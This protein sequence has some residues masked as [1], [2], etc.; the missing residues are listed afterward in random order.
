MMS[1]SEVEALCRLL[2]RQERLAVAHHDARAFPAA[3]GFLR[4]IH[5]HPVLASAI[6]DLVAD[7]LRIREGHVKQCRILIKKLQHWCDS[8]EAL[9]GQKRVDLSPDKDGPFSE[10]VRE[11]LQ[12]DDPDTA[13]CACGQLQDIFEELT[14]WVGDLC[15]NAGAE[16]L[17]QLKRSGRA[18]R[19][20][21]HF[22]T[23][24]RLNMRAAGEILPGEAYEALCDHVDVLFPR[25]LKNSKGRPEVFSPDLDS[26]NKAWKQVDEVRLFPPRDQVVGGAHICTLVQR[27]SI[28]LQTKL[29]ERQS[30]RSLVRKFATRCESFEAKRI[31]Q[32]AGR[33]KGRVEAGLTLEFARYLFDAGYSPVLNPE[34]SGLKPDIVDIANPP[35]I[36]VEVKQCSRAT[37]ALVRKAVSQVRQTWQVFAN[38]FE[39][40][41]AILLV[42]RLNGPTLDLPPEI[43]TSQG[44]LLI[45]VV[46]VAPAAV[47]GSRASAPLKMT[48][49]D[50]LDE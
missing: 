31:R 33:S 37:R 17:E 15:Q 10:T 1:A 35:A 12:P 25:I 47:S 4:F 8:N 3:A 45:Q 11:I 19:Y 5:T 50:I 41:E 27:T 18:L 29:V 30:Q 23:K 36:Y 32:D 24:S 43:R 21:G 7:A 38:R 13:W 49:S 48:E 16:R 2:E 28:A 26:A 22:Y 39:A 14:A 40:S 6:D 9:F 44:V 42:F 20:L 34:I 46:N